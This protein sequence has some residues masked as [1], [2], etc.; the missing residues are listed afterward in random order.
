MKTAKVEIS[1]P[2]F[3]VWC[4]SCCLRIAPLENEK[5]SGIRRITL[6]A[7]LSSP[8][9][10]EHQNCPCKFRALPFTHG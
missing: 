6:A 1:K 4:E 10:P 8:R 3:K 7:T 5:W 9:K 2:D